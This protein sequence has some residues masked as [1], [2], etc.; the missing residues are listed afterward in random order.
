MVKFSFAAIAGMTA[1]A[2]TSVALAPVE[3]S[4]DRMR[5]YLW[6]QRPLL[7]FAPS[8][9][10]A[11]LKRQLGV[12]R[13]NRAG[14]SERDM[15][16]II[17]AEDRVSM[18]MGAGSGAGATALRRRFGVGGEEFRVILVGKDGGAKLSSR[19]PVSASRLF[20]LIDSMPMRQQEM[21]RQRG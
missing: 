18:A 14:F 10:A 16:V 2:L 19:A 4:A 15:V 11:A 6:Q 12:V 7:V 21:Q 8:S 9:A 1:A 17:V 13:A 3:A 5:R 20:Q